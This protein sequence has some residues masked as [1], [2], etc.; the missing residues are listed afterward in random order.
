MAEKQIKNRPEFAEIKDW[1]GEHLSKPNNLILGNDTKNRAV[2]VNSIKGPVPYNIPI[3]T[4]ETIQQFK[5]A[6][7]DVYLGCLD[8][9]N[10]EVSNLFL[11]DSLTLEDENTVIVGNQKFVFSNDMDSVS[12]INTLERITI[13]YDAMQKAKQQANPISVKT[14]SVEITNPVNIEPKVLQNPIPKQQVEPE[15]LQNIKLKPVKQ[16]N[17]S[18]RRQVLSENFVC[19]KLSDDDVLSTT[20]CQNLRNEQLVFITCTSLNK[21]ENTFR[22]N[23]DLFADNIKN[24]KRAAFISGRAIKPDQVIKEVSKINKLCT[25]ALN[26]N[27]VMY[28]VNNE[29]IQSMGSDRETIQNA[30]VAIEQVLVALNSEKYRPMICLDKETLETIYKVTGAGYNFKF[31]TFL[32]ILPRELDEVQQTAN[33]V[34]MDPQYDN[35]QVVIKNQNII[36]YLGL[37]EQREPVIENEY[38]QIEE[39]LVKMA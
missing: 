7:I 39:H 26:T 29:A 2:I 21:G 15:N 5:D 9:L 16:V 1:I 24:V 32:R 25:N 35:D 6:W 3:K 23:A 19:Q 13:A 4:K 22:D 12:Y 18:Q 37:D 38:E 34:I 36:N 28:E 8:Y 14:T 31:P 17:P 20:D 10:K 27:V 33:L 11:K 30:I